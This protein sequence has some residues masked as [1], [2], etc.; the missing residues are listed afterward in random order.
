[1]TAVKSQN[2]RNQRRRVAQKMKK[3][4][5]GFIP[6]FSAAVI[7]VLLS[8]NLWDNLI[9]I[10]KKDD[11]ISS[12]SQEHKSRRIK[13]EA[14]NEKVMAEVDDEYIAE[15]AAENGYRNSDEII[16]YLISGD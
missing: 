2:A 1:M 12:L 8:V 16:F 15:V 9:N 6:V 5:L 14:M 7:I 11:T 13:N 3:H 10:R 4:K